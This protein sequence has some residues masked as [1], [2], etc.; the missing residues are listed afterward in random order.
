M[1]FKLSD[2]LMCMDYLRVEEQ[3]KILDENMDWHHADI[4][5]GHFC[6]NITLSPDF[7]KSVAGYSKLP[8]DVHLMVTR[9]QD[10]LEIFAKAGAKMLT[11]HAETINAS[12]FRIIRRIRSLGCKVGI[13]LNPATPLVYI[14]TFADEIDRLT[15]MSVDVGYAGQAVIPQVFAKIKEA[16]E[17]RKKN[18]LHYEI[19]ID[20]CCNQTTYRKYAQAGADML[21]M[22][23]GMFGRDPDLKKCIEIARA[24]QR[25]ATEGIV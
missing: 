3:L 21:V 5:D 9:P 12:A 10:W 8:I 15:L 13:A 1:Q 23:S 2:S 18:H 14:E 20:G 6:P 24:E 16:Y 11:V 17:F 7:V 19:Q 22:G 4:M 25:E